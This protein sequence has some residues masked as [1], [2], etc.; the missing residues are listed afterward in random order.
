MGEPRLVDMRMTIAAICLLALP[1][2]VSHGADFVDPGF[3]SYTVSAGEFV[4]PTS[5]SWLFGANTDA[6]VVEPYSPN[7]S[8]GPLDTWSATLV[9][10]E[11]QQYASTYAGGDTIRQRVMFGAVGDYW[12]SVYA[13]AP[14]GSVTI[15]SVGTLPLV[16]GE[17]TFT[18][19]SIPFSTP[20]IVPKGSSW[21]LYRVLLSIGEPAPYT[22]GIANTRTAAYFINY[23]SFSIQPVPEPSTMAVLAMAL[24]GFAFLAWR[25]RGRS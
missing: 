20:R 25:R 2:R 22:I 17:F 19:E 12:I 1:L 10:H 4:K 7:S 9:A 23:D 15:P 16:D 13:A 24:A 3:E 8:N 14:D 5:G 18:L 6:G 11:G 21:S